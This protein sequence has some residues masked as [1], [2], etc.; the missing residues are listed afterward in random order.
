MNISNI[1]LSG[2]LR[3]IIKK[4]RIG[5]Y[6]NASAELNEALLLIQKAVV[7]NKAD[8]GQNLQKLA[9]SLNTLYTMQKIGDWVAVADILE[10]EFINLLINF[11]QKN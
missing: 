1:D 2:L 10:Y 3:I 11:L 8:S 7:I 9:I 5:D 6:G 4:I